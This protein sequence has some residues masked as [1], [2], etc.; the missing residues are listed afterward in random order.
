MANT[1]A[2]PRA[3]HEPS[4]IFSQ[5]I[6]HPPLNASFELAGLTPRSSDKSNSPSIVLRQSNLRKSYKDGGGMT[7]NGAAICFRCRVGLCPCLFRGSG[8]DHPVAFLSHPLYH[9]VS[10]I[11]RINSHVTF[12]LTGKPYSH[13]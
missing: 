6:R 7:T 12:L 8:F 1:I 11:N 3:L 9:S 5:S 10:H 4:L 2:P 13:V